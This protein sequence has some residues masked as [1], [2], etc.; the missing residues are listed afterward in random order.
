MNNGGV[1]NEQCKEFI[2]KGNAVLP[3]LWWAPNLLNTQDIIGYQHIGEANTTDVEDQ[4]L[5]VKKYIAL[6]EETLQ[7]TILWLW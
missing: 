1:R 6:I 4:I 3:E 7:M 2:D 5:T